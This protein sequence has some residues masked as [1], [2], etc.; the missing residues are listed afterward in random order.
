MNNGQGNGH[1][2][3]LDPKPPSDD[4]VGI[5]DL[6]EAAE[7]AWRNRWGIPGGKPDYTSRERKSDDD[8]DSPDKKN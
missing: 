2:Q 7:R 3:N 5:E 8:V 6:R 4:D 1:G